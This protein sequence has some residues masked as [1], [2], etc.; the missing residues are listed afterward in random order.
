MPESSLLVIKG[1]DQGTRFLCTDKT[2]SIG[3][4]AS[5]TI[6]ILDSEVSRQHAIMEGD[7]LCWRVTDLQSS[8]GT[9]VNGKKITQ[10]TVLQSGD[11]LEIGGTTMVFSQ[12]MSGISIHRAADLV[13]MIPNDDLSDHSQIVSH[14]KIPKIRPPKEDS[15]SKLPAAE[16]TDRILRLIYEISEQ[17]VQ[18][19]LTLDELLQRIL[20]KT[21]SVLKADRGCVLLADSGDDEITPLVFTHS[22]PQL[23]GTPM[24]VSR[25]IV[26]YVLRN[27]Q[28]VRTT[29]ASHDSRFAPGKS[30]LRA[31]VREAL[32][33]PIH[34]RFKMLG[35]IYV[36]CT[37]SSLSA[38]QE[39]QQ[40]TRF[41]DEQLKILLVIGRQVALA[42]ENNQ[43]QESLLKAERL[44]AVGQ[45]I[46]ILSHHIKNILQGIRGG[47]YLI[48]QGL[49][50][51]NN[52][53]I[54]QGWKIVDKNQDRIYNL[55]MDM[56]TF[57]K[58][59]QPEQSPV[60]LNDVVVDISELLTSRAEEFDI[61]IELELDPEIPISVFDEEGIHRAV[62]NV[63]A[64]GIDAL[65]QQENGILKISTHFD[66]QRNMLSVLVEDNGPGMDTEHLKKIFNLFE[67]TKGARG[68]GLGLAV[69]RKILRE[70]DGEITVR[71]VVGKG[72]I[73]S[74]NWPYIQHD[75]TVIEHHT[76]GS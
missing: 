41:N 63:G 19:S 68:T 11:Q 3:R 39:P 18:P 51:E 44:A 59:R 45:T 28:G 25:S 7:D 5:S 66:R 48:D 31:G 26:D 71:S 40:S 8:N 67:S 32:C 53:T 2:I 76:H 34:S 55:V 17:A 12:G 69:S 35:A 47:G 75:Q 36:D 9:Y 21:V 64:N 33:V 50:H 4:G 15:Q 6:R 27:D 43:F 30:I 13:R 1:T 16:D 62:L 49:E 29:D 65:N 60:L 42:I 72:T 54:R 20:D 23:A 57:G 22:N 70:H 52:E 37:V 24:T 61:K 10:Q 56:L 73:F 14:L 46:A 58:E 38:M 74:L